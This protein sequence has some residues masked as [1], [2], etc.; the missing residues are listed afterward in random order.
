MTSLRDIPGFG[1]VV[2]TLSNLIGAFDNKDIAFA[3]FFGILLAAIAIW[4]FFQFWKHRPCVRPI[5]D[6]ANAL[7]RLENETTDP[8]AGIDKAHEVFNEKR[9]DEWVYPELRK[10][11]G[12]YRK[13]LE[14]NPEGPGLLNLVDPRLW[15]SLESL[16]GRGYEQWCA[17]WAGVFLTIGLLFT[18][19]GLSA[20][21]MKVGGIGG[22]SSAA[23]KEAITGIL[24]SRGHHN[25]F[26]HNLTA[27]YSGR[28]RPD[29]TANPRRKG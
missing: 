28:R 5:R 22:T 17:T 19:I 2:D 1:A 23:M 7:R 18:F 15:F 6:V 13:H 29:D 26:E 10:L 25:C 21:L 11:W 4:L 9:K 16:P 27:T 14:T 20:A 24:G 3:I 12:E 8:Q